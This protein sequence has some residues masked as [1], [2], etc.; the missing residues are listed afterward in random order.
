M[1]V[2]MVFLGGFIAGV[3]AMLATLYLAYRLRTLNEATSD[4]AE[5]VAYGPRM[6][7]DED[8]VAVSGTRRIPLPP[9]HEDE[10]AA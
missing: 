9:A 8:D 7:E 5:P 2:V 10:K 4:V 6:Q 3:V 1:T